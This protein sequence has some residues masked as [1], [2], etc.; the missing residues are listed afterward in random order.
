MRTVRCT[1]SGGDHR[2]SIAHRERPRRHHSHEA[3][4]PAFE[5][6]PE[7][8]TDLVHALA[9]GARSG[10]LEHRVTDSKPRAERQAIE[11]EPAHRHL[12]AHVAGLEAERLEHFGLHEQHL[13]P[14]ALPGVPI[15]LEAVFGHRGHFVDRLERGAARRNI[16]EAR[17]RSPACQILLRFESRQHHGDIVGA[18]AP[19]GERDQIPAGLLEIEIGGDLRDLGIRHQSMQPI[20]A[21]EQRVA[22]LERGFDPAGVDRHGAADADAPRHQVAPW[23]ALRLLR[24]DLSALDQ[25]RHQRMV[26]RELVEVAF[27]QQVRP[28]VPDMG[29]EDLVVLDHERGARG[30]H[31]AQPGL[32]EALLM[33][34]LVRGFHRFREI[35]QH[36]VAGRLSIRSDH[37]L[38][39]EPARDLAAACA[40]HPVGDDQEHARGRSSETQLAYWSSFCA[41]LSPGCVADFTVTVIFASSRSTLSAA[42]PASVATIGRPPSADNSRFRTRRACPLRRCDPR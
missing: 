9:G 8:G 21:K 1:I 35:G 13:P 4:A 12:L 38:H 3:A 31:A 17:P 27:M 2:K 37:G 32:G 20:G 26:L 33:D 30:S 7:S 16:D 15:A 5:H 18:A 10:H 6:V 14:A 40:A 22:L 19:V 36:P 23:I 41:R 39:G 25:L 11:P 24:G 42:R 29:E 34:G 28:T